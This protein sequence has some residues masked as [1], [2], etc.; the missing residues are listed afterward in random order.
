MSPTE[1]QQLL[2][3][4]NLLLVIG[5]VIYTWLTG[6]S[7]VNETQ[8]TDL[9]KRAS[10]HDRR[11]DK[12]ETDMRHLP[13]KDVTHRMENSLTEMNG[14]IAVLS[15]RLTPIAAISERLQEFMLEKAR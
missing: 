14:K 2:S 6:R 15:E 11:I 1:I 5:A 13:D 8:I 3:I 10:E 9:N 7:R 4:A 12:I